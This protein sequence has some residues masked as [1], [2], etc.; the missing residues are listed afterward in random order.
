[1]PSRN[2][3]MRLITAENSDRVSAFKFVYGRLNG[4]KQVTPVQ[5]MDQM[6]DD[7][8]IRLA[9]K[10]IAHFFQVIAKYIVV[11]DNAVMHEGDAWSLCSQ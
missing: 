5:V 4:L 3:P 6:R 11:L 7:L 1:M 9:F 10:L 2:N 8:G